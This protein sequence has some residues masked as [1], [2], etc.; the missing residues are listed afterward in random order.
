MSRNFWCAL[1]ALCSLLVSFD[2]DAWIAREGNSD[3]P[4]CT[5]DFRAFPTGTIDVVLH[6]GACPVADRFNDLNSDGAV[7]TETC[8]TLNRFEPQDVQDMM[9][10]IHEAVNAIP[11]VDIDLQLSTSNQ[12][13]TYGDSEGDVTPTIHVGFVVDTTIISGAA[14]V[15]TPEPDIGGCHFMEQ[16]MVVTDQSITS[17]TWDEPTAFGTP[18]YQAGQFLSPPNSRSLRMVYMHELLHTLGLAHVT[19]TYSMLNNTDRPFFDFGAGRMVQPLPDDIAALR[20][21]YDDGRGLG[22]TA[23]T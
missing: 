9:L 21:L 14:A 17:W 22:W 23:T 2:A 16:H 20:T 19:E 10:D 7:D 1:V 5:Q 8:D 3:D 12:P 15:R 4:N 13:F 18:W 11:G 6:Y